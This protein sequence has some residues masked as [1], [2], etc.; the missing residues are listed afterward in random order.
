MNI[1]SVPCFKTRHQVYAVDVDPKLANILHQRVDRYYNEWSPKLHCVISDILQMEIPKDIDHII[2]NV[3]YQ[4]SSELIFKL[5]ASNYFESAILIFQEEFAQ[6]LKSRCNSK[7]YSRLSVN[8][9]MHCKIERILKIDRGDFQ[10]PPHVDSAVVRLT[11]YSNADNP[12]T[13]TVDGD[14]KHASLLLD[15]YGK[16]TH[17]ADGEREPQDEELWR[18]KQDEY[19]QWN[20]FLKVCFS[21]KN[22]KL[23]SVFDSALRETRQRIIGDNAA[24]VLRDLIA[25]LGLNQS[26]ANG[27]DISSFLRLFEEI[28]S[29][30]IRFCATE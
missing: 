25:S 6:K 15:N 30:N 10:P 8:A 7:Q 2:S 19:V 22:K 28:R 16:Y 27:I 26:R 5:L 23:P 17:S 14:W 12:W 1:D 9:Q 4:I 13:V 18:R 3:P 29:R 11:P 20:E 24:V 21:H